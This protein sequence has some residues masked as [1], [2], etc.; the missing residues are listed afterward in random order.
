LYLFYAI[1]DE[2]DFYIK[3]VALDETRSCGN[4]SIPCPFGVEPG[5]Y[6]AAGFNLTC[7]YDGEEGSPE[8]FLGDDGTVQVLEISFPNATVS[9]SIRAK[10]IYDR[11]R[12]TENRTWG[13]DLTQHGT[14]PYHLSQKYNALPRGMFCYQPADNQL[15]TWCSA[16]SPPNNEGG[17]GGHLLHSG[18]VNCY[19]LYKIDVGYSFYTIQIHRLCAIL[20]N[21]GGS[22]RIVDQD[23]SD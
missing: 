14:Y 3:I 18:T 21:N 6:H 2:D 10:L 19:S 1:S 7:R 11:A 17:G 12:R 23:N 16:I 13:I 4:I 20:N 22:V 15:I 9:T 5:C 8:L